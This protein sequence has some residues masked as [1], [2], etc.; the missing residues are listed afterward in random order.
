M[1]DFKLYLTEAH[2]SSEEKLTHLEH[3]EDHPINAGAAGFAHAKKTLVGVHDAMQGKK[4]SVSISTKYDGS[5]SIVFGHHP[6][7]GKFFVASKSAFNKT[8][9]I[10]YSEKDVE[11]NHGHAPGLAT[12]LKAALKHL[13]KVTPK[14]GVFQGDIMHSGGKTKLNPHGDVTMHGG[15]AS[16]TPN[17][18]T[19]TTKK[20]GEAEQASNAK[21]GVAVH[22]A[23][24]G[25]TFDKLK[26]KFNTGHEGFGTHKDVHMMDVTHD[27]PKSKLTSD[28]SALFHEHMANAEEHHNALGKS[29]YDAI[30]GAHS[31][32]LKTYINKTVK[33]DEVP[34]A[35]GYKAHLAEIHQKQADKVSTPA[36]KTEKIGAG[37]ELTSHVDAN[38]EHFNHALSM[39]TY[40]QA[41]KNVLVHSLAS[42]TDYGHT[43]GGK[44]VKPEGHVAVINN[45]PTK[46]VDRQ[47]FSK[48]NFEKNA[49]R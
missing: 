41:A 5:P 45:R 26:A 29:G 1:I 34:S 38:V 24:H 15:Q 12:K 25:P 43:I 37:K 46:L 10:N 7:T 23:Y 16:Y 2:A 27:A 17:T 48:L 30:G 21:I 3:A 42:H 6:E 13:P 33:T 32:H 18:I 8:P 39:H 14:T 47:E 36:K 35:E 4:S 22:T 19:Y 31:D 11:E 28:Q 40:L 49:K 20:S 44:K 9:K